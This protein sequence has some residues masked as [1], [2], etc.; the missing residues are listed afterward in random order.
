MGTSWGHQGSYKEKDGHLVWFFFKEGI[1]ALFNVD[2]SFQVGKKWVQPWVRSPMGEL[3][4]FI[5]HAVH[6]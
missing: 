6:V 4:S 2:K 3:E 5:M 1:F